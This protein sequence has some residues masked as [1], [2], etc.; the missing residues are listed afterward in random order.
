MRSVLIAA[1]AV[2]VAAVALPAQALEIKGAGASFPAP[3]YYAWIEAY[4]S[5]Q[6]DVAVRYE[7][8]GSGEGIDRF[9]AGAVD[10]GASDAAMSDKEIAKVERGVVMIPATAGMVVVAYN[11]P[12]FEGDLRL[13]RAA[14]AGIFS[15]EIKD[16][17][18]P[19]ILAANPGVAFPH[20]TIGL[21]ARRDSSGTTF[22][23]T[24]HL[25]AA[26][27]AWRD[28][29][30]GVGK[31]VRWPGGAMT[32]RGN[33]GVAARIRISDYALGYV[34]YNFARQ[35]SLP[36]A[37]LENRDGVYVAPA[38]ESGAAALASVVAEMPENGR[39][40]LPD[41]AGG[42]SY[43]ITSYTWLLLYK[44]YGD[45]A[46]RDAVRGFVDWG[47]GAGQEFSGKIGYI[48][49][50]ESVAARARSLLASVE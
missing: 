25:G 31:L 16:W 10:F 23:F 3:L 49:L 29:G 38:A 12:G 6:P 46:K 14:L 2:V 42:A 8:V 37:L 5:V 39:Q 47:L 7:S 43:P 15:G 41:P 45:A 11:I 21:V 33:E 30:P 28:N 20:R 35:L 24:N 9:V 19:R 48:P 32:A 44:R 50:P 18:D 26:S 36:M 1:A 27:G 34:E 13:S 17:D 22:A 4:R 40:F